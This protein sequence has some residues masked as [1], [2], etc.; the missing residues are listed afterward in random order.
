MSAIEYNARQGYSLEIIE[1]IQRTVGAKPDGKW[2]KQTVRQIKAWQ[3]ANDL[4]VDG[5][6]GPGTLAEFEKLWATDDDVGDDE[7]LDD[8]EERVQPHRPGFDEGD[9][10]DLEHGPVAETSY[11]DG[12]DYF[13]LDRDLQ[14][15]S[16]GDDVFALQNDLFA[17]GFEPG[18]PDGDLGKAGVAAIEAFQRVCQTRDR[19]EGYAR[20]VREV[21]FEG[22]VTGVVDA[23]TRAEIRRWKTNRWTW[24]ALDGDYSPRRVRVK[25]LGTLPRS[26]A[27][28]R[29]VPSAGQRK[30]YL[31]RLAAEALDAMNLAAIADGIVPLAAASAWRRHRW[32]SREHYKE[33]M[34]RNYG[35]V[36]EGMKWVAFASPHETGLAIDFG[37]GGLEPRR[38]TADRQRETALFKWLVQHAYRFGWRPYRREPWH[39]E[40]PLSLRAWTL[41]LS[42]WRL[43]V[44]D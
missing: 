3:R 35:S 10:V 31:H 29:E 34:I 11:E 40:F 30:K 39:W 8:V 14:R 38:K 27:L 37:V 12:Y 16:K 43:K 1:R 26:S 33:V 13:D 36:R 24:I 25:N 20:V 5:K 4:A 2:G 19:I 28:L 22:A 15:G 9:D 32:K 7:E 44:E 21:T 42:D 17:F 6:V 23:A 18:K 41:G